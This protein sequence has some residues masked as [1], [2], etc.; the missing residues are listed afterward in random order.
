VQEV[1]GPAELVAE[2]IAPC[3]V[4]QKDCCFAMVIVVG[5]AVV[6]EAKP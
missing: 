4:H 1:P 6:V 2:P 3:L 5:V